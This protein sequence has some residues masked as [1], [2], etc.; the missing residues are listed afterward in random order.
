MNFETRNPATGELIEQYDFLPDSIL[1]QRLD[2][3]RQAA[4]AWAAS[5]FDSRSALMKSVAKQL[6]KQRDSLAEMVSLEMGKLLAEA[7]VEIDKCISACDYYA[8]NAESMLQDE[9]VET[10][11]KRSLISYDPIGVVLAVMPWNFPLWQVFRC[12]VPALMSGNGLLLKHAPNVPKC[13]QAIEQILW[14]AGSPVGLV[15]NLMISVEQTG[16]VIADP[17][18]QG[19]SFTG[20]EGAGRQIA[21]LAGQNLKKLVLELGGSDPFIVLEDADL[22]RAVDVAIAARYANAGQICIAA[23]RFLVVSERVQEFTD[24]LVARASLLEAGDPQAPDTTLGPMARADLRD[25]LHQQVQDSISQGAKPLL[26]CE[27]LA[28]DGYYYAPSVLAGVEPGMTAFNE[29]IFGP[30]A[31]IVEVKD[32][33]DAVAKANAT[34]FGLGACVWTRD[35]KRGEKLLRQLDV[36]NAFLNGQVR[37]DI[38]MPFGGTKSSGLGRELGASGIREFCNAKSIWIDG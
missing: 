35:I 7:Y 23:K 16:R 34:R 22:D 19:V 6:H 18:V 14:D 3:A 1:E 5:S 20:S 17:R 31:S 21:A 10:P 27:P 9:L 13:A 25:Q 28:G 4:G 15:T 36:G 8:D 29:E 11:A 38:R 32:E 37:S 24:L 33:A 26:G 2:S 12:L 30:V